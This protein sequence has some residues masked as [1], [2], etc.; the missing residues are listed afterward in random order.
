MSFF[1]TNFPGVRTMLERE[2]EANN[3]T[4]ERETAAGRPWK[5]MTLNLGVPEVESSHATE[6]EARDAL[7]EIHR[8]CAPFIRSAFWVEED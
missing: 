2:R 7:A 8:T 4:G 3:A 6:A 1:E 5:V